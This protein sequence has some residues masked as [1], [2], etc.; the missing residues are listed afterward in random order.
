L[1]RNKRKEKTG[2]YLFTIIFNLILLYIFNNLLNWHVYF[3]TTALNEILWII[4]LAIIITIIG[5]FL[6]LL[7]HPEWLRH[8]TKMI[9]NIF[10]FIAVYYLYKVFPFNFHNSF[11]NWGLSILLILGLIGLAIAIIVEFSLMLNKKP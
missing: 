2:E 5:N 7:Y 8:L 11:L 6:L 1:E 10:S 9:L 3:I 4:N